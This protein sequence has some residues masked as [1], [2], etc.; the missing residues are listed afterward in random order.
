MN[1]VEPFDQKLNLQCIF[2]R[3]IVWNLK[4][5]LSPATANNNREHEAEFA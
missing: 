3:Q 4:I 2:I 5:V 1:S